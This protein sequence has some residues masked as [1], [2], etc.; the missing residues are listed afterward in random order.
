MQKLKELTKWALSIVILLTFCYLVFLQ[1][2]IVPIIG[3]LLFFGVTTLF[4]KWFVI[5]P[6]VD[7]V[8]GKMKRL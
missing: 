3:V 6:M 4:V 7:W 2:L 1:P 8:L 5:D